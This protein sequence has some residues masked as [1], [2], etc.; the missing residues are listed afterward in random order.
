MAQLPEQIPTDV[1][2]PGCCS[3]SSQKMQSLQHS[4]PAGFWILKIGSAQWRRDGAGHGYFT[5]QVQKSDKF[6]IAVLQAKHISMKI[7]IRSP[8]STVAN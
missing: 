3:N 1:I 4:H 6:K 2:T 7:C 5:S 8:P